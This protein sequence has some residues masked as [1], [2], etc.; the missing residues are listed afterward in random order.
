MR[1][2]PNNELVLLPRYSNV[3]RRAWWLEI[4]RLTATLAMS[5]VTGFVVALWFRR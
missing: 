4:L 1:W 2:G 3:S 5:T